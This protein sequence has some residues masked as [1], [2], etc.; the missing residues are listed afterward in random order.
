MVKKQTKQI[1]CAFHSLHFLSHDQHNCNRV[2][3]ETDRQGAKL[4]EVPGAR[5]R[6]RGRIVISAAGITCRQTAQRYTGAE[7]E[8]ERCSL[9]IVL[10][11]SVKTPSAMPAGW[12]VTAGLSFN[13]AWSLWLKCSHVII[14]QPSRLYWSLSSRLS[15]RRYHST[16][17]PCWSVMVT[18]VLGSVVTSLLFN[19]TS[20]LVS[21]VTSL[22]F[23]LTSLLKSDG[24][25]FIGIHSHVITIQ[26]RVFIGVYRHVVIIEP[27]ILV[28]VWWSRLYWGL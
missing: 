10:Q 7:V 28:E 12:W 17:H 9:V 26:P 18:S 23:N 24:Y 20:L 13:L 27:H 6:K 15:S 21:I 16:S 1:C 8:S 19:L 14:I 25:V 3:T 22:S 4:A 2:T 5:V 11:A